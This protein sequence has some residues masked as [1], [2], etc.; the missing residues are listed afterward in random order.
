MTQRPAIILAY[1]VKSEDGVENQTLKPGNNYYSNPFWN[2][3]NPKMI[4]TPGQPG[5]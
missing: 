3:S 4:P 2:G 1:A 5:S